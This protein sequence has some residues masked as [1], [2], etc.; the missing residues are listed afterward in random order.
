[1]KILEEKYKERFPTEDMYSYNIGKI[2]S[3]IIEMFD[4]GCDEFRNATTK[5]NQKID[6]KTVKFSL[7]FCDW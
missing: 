6:G 2:F 4:L 1:M 7:K 3:E 5:K